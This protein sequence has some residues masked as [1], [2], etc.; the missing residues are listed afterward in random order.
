METREDEGFYTLLVVFVY[1]S[2]DHTCVLLCNKSQSY[3]VAFLLF[4]YVCIL[5]FETGKTIYQIPF[6]VKNHIGKNIETCYK[7]FKCLNDYHLF[8]LFCPI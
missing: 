2:G 3:I 6:K 4:L 7:V 5:Q 1:L 8:L